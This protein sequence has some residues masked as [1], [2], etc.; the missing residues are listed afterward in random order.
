MSFQKELHFVVLLGS[1]RAGS[2]NGIV[3]RTLPQIAPPGVSISQLGSIADF[4]HY[5][6]DIQDN[7]IPESVSLMADKI[8]EADGLIIVTPEYNYSIPGVLKN[9]IDWLSR[10]TPQPLAGKPVAIQTVS[11]GA[12]GGARAQYHLRQS[13]VFLDAF[14][15]NKP[16]AMIGQASEKFDTESLELIDQ[17]TKDFLVRQINALADLTRKIAS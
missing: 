5:S 1:L 8:R 15:L 2:L 7:G 10:L 12:I 16:E 14:V 11:P 9:A 17:K 6:Q 4:P 13:L 3:A